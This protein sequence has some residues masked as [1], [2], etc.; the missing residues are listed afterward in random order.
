MEQGYICN[1]VMDKYIIDSHDNNIDKRHVTIG[2]LLFSGRG[3]IGFVLNMT[4][5]ISRSI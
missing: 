1:P 2:K 3:K 4:N 5:N